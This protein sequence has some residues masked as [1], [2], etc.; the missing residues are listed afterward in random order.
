MAAL[1][2]AT[3]RL[4]GKS[5]FARDRI[6]YVAPRAAKQ[7]GLSAQ[8]IYQ[9]KWRAIVASDDVSKR[10]ASL[11]DRWLKETEHLSSITQIVLNPAYQQIIGMG[12][13]ALPLIFAE[14]AER[15]HHWFWALNAITGENPVPA[16]SVGD[17][18]AMREA[19][20]QWAR[21]RGHLG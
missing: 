9:T 15:P 19:W 2:R 5:I 8:R 6:T 1:Y 13:A 3:E 14:L 10:F 16:E 11:K 7:L 12:P 21:K 17:L 20:F 18:D 4:G